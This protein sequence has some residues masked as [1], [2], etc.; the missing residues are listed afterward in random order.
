VIIETCISHFFSDA[1]K[2]VARRRRTFGS[3][4]CFLTFLLCF[5]LPVTVA[6]RFSGLLTDPL[7][8]EFDVV[9]L[10]F[11]W[12][13]R[14]DSNDSS[15]AV[16]LVVV[17][18]KF[19]P[20]LHWRSIHISSAPILKYLPDPP[21]FSLSILVS[22]E[23]PMFQSLLL[24]FSDSSAPLSSASRREVARVYELGQILGYRMQRLFLVLAWPNNN[25]FCWGSSSLIFFM[26]S[27]DN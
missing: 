5:L 18:L 13:R 16:S 24:A 25:L 11:G 15:L 26:G 1:D 27:I 4:I 10:A 22:S 20:V 8:T 17:G 21:A 14:A 2:V 6:L 23:F 19:V 9:S 12:F 7:L 3:A